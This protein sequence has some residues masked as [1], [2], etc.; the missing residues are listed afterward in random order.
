[1]GILQTLSQRW[2][3]SSEPFLIRG[4]LEVTFSDIQ[5]AQG[6]DLADV[7]QGDVVALIGDFEPNA[8][9][10]LLRLIDLG[11]ILVPLTTDTAHQQDYLFDAACVDVVIQDGVLTRRQVAERSLMV[12]ELAEK[13]HAGLV[14]FSS[15]TTGK[16]KAILHDL[17]Q[18]L[19]RYNTIRPTLRTINFLLFDHIGGINTLLHTLYNQGVIIAP[20]SRAVSDVLDA[21]R[22]H[23]VELLP[24]TP[25]FLRMIL[26]SGA[27]EQDFPKSIKIVTYG[28]E[29]MDQL[30]LSQ[31]CE[32]LPEVDFRQT[33]GMSELGILRSK[34]EGR[35]S[36]FMKIGGEGVETKI[37]DGVLKIRSQTRMMGYMNAPSPF[38]DEGWYNTKDLIETNGDY[39]KVTGRDSDVINV[40]GLK[41][42]AADVE[43]VALGIPGVKMVKVEGKPNP[44]TGQHVILT[45]ELDK[46]LVTLEQVKG[47]LKDVL[48]N[49]MQPQRYKSG[50]VGVSHRFKRT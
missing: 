36:L 23:D 3:G 2:E 26:I 18:F 46:N 16:P 30:T 13:G 20:E 28:T 37:E 1:M 7:N 21:C 31:L 4:D 10:T 11:V 19:Q 50:K 35:D 27:L 17:E 43:T 33:F 34:S 25:T 48:P 14:L 45:C 8:I 44:I 42:M 24:T 6:V 47:H 38:D 39:I 9:I 40:G 49:H 15:G 29:R 12:K 32:A 41:F 5:N 22:K